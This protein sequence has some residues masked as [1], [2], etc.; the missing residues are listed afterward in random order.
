MTPTATLVVSLRRVRARRLRSERFETSWAR[1]PR[2]Q[3]SS[4]PAG[5]RLIDLADLWIAGLE[6]EGRIEQTTI[7]EY[8]RV[9]DN[10]VLPSAGGLKLGWTG[11][12]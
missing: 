2:Q 12:C 4:L 9:L 11:S 7:N 3:V 6:T 10:L 1:A 8:R 5:T